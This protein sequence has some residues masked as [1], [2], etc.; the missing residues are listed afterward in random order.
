MGHVVAWETSRAELR[1]LTLSSVEGKTAAAIKTDTLNM[2]A[3]SALGVTTVNLRYKL[4]D[5]DVPTDMFPGL[6]INGSFTKF[7]RPS[8]YLTACAAGARFPLALFVHV[9]CDDDTPFPPVTLELDHALLHKPDSQPFINA[10]LTLFPFEHTKPRFSQAGI[11]LAG[12][13]VDVYTG[14]MEHPVMFHCALTDSAHRAIAHR[15]RIL[16]EIIST[17]ETYVADLTNINEYWQRVVCAR[18]EVRFSAREENLIFTDIPCIR[19]THRNFK[20]SLQGRGTDYTCQ[21]A[22]LFLDFAPMFR[23]AA[24]YVSCYQEINAA[25]N[26]LLKNPRFAA[27]LQR[28]AEQNPNGSTRNFGSYLITPVQRIPRYLLFL[29]ELMKATPAGHPDNLLL[30]EAL[31]FVEGLVA[32]MDAETHKAINYIKLIDIQSHI[33]NPKACPPIAASD[34]VCVREFAVTLLRPQSGPG[35]L[36]VFNDALLLCASSKKGDQTVVLWRCLEAFRFSGSYDTADTSWWN[37]HQHLRVHCTFRFA[38]P[39]DFRQF[40]ECTASNREEQKS[41]C[42]WQNALFQAALEP[43]YGAA[44]FTVGGDVFFVGGESGGRDTAGCTQVNIATGCVAV[45]TCPWS[46]RT[47][48]TV[49]VVNGVAYLLWGKGCT[50]MWALKHGTWNRFEVPMS[51]QPRAFHSAVV[52]NNQI[53]VYG[54]QTKS[55]LSNTVCMLDPVK[56]Q[57][58]ARELI[59]PIKARYGHSAAVW[60]DFMVISFGRSAKHPR[61]DVHAMNLRTFEWNEI[62]SV[63]ARSG[64]ITL[65][66][67]RGIL[68][69]LGENEG[70]KANAPV[71]LE[72]GSWTAQPFSDAGNWPSSLVGAAVVEVD[73]GK[74]VIFG[75]AEAEEQRQLLDAAYV[76]TVTDPTAVAEAPLSSSVGVPLSEFQRA[77]EPHLNSSKNSLLK[78]PP[79]ARGEAP[80]P[81]SE[82]PAEGGDNPPPGVVQKKESLAD[83][84]AES[85]RCEEAQRKAALSKAQAQEEKRPSGGLSTLVRK[86]EEQKRGEKE[87]KGKGIDAIIPL[88]RRRAFSDTNAP[89]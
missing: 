63:R 82:A 64:H 5:R 61:Q 77:N 30:S 88:S 12:S 73:V 75:G 3:D 7:R 28:L 11:P 76:L 2:P 19:D 4:A 16:N 85:V 36:F 69:V 65:P 21:I 51:P 45:S 25:L 58:T 6:V 18:T 66:L 13:V 1:K 78:K 27:G 79:S 39:D 43:V 38:T 59:T 17:E 22:D 15:S 34:R 8:I 44:A 57:W 86:W 71:L 35:T 42:H 47:G 67:A 52:W 24:G 89:I 9:S 70:E 53:V 81:P 50:D 62:S 32:D 74:F 46:P 48:H 60:Q 26:T 23:V 72:G 56:M 49:S 31:Q 14:A 20:Q 10:F 80:S 37:K 83:R 87:Q 40:V 33:I 54:G 84:W 29:R 55:G 68:F 41:T